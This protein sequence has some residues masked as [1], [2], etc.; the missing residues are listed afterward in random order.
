M[1]ESLPQETSADTKL[2]YQLRIQNLESQLL[3]L[4]IKYE[5]LLNEC[6][7]LKRDNVQLKRMPLF[8]ATVVDCFDNGE[9]YLRQT[10]NNQEF[11]SIVPHDLRA[12]IKSGSKVAVNGTL[13]IVKVIPDTFDT[14][15]RLMELDSAPDITFEQVG[16]LTNVIEEVREAVEYPLTRPEIFERIGVE[17]PKGILLYGPPGTGKTLIA[18]A[19]AHSAHA[20]FIRMSGSELVHKYIGEGAQLV[21]ELFMMAHDKAPSIIF[22]DE[23]DSIGSTRSNDGTSGSAEVQRTMMQLLAE[24]DGFNNRGN[25]RIMAATNRVDMLDVALLR[26]GRFDRIIEV[27]LPDETARL[28]ILK[29]HSRKMKFQDVDLEQIVSMT[30]GC[31]GAELQSICREAGMIAVR[32]EADA[33]GMDDMI[34]GVHKVMHSEDEKVEEKHDMYV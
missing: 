28:E 18:I 24:M 21:R 8:I 17:P 26:P 9:I 30:D 34:A 16:G 33:V 3:D 31:T 20:Q 25:V 22:I 23:I 14:R 13:S 27:G 32:N 29:I 2:S 19:V 15:V 6:S 12:V 11:L 7:V 1:D 4:T 10:G 5:D